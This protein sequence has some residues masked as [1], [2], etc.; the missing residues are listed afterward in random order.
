[1]LLVNLAT[2]YQGTISTLRNTQQDAYAL[3]RVHLRYVLTRDL[4]GHLAQLLLDLSN[5]H[6]NSTRPI[7][8]T[9]RHK[10]EDA[11][12]YTNIPPAHNPNRPTRNRKRA[13]QHADQT[14]YTTTHTNELNATSYLQPRL[15]LSPQ[16]CTLPSSSPAS[17]KP[18]V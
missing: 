6:P 14:N 12:G 11:E 5:T 1:M 8:H 10:Q 17:Y 9:N 3:S 7:T 13:I 2:I 18:R 15:L 4:D 16:P